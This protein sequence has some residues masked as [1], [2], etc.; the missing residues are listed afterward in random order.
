MTIAD[1]ILALV[2]LI[3]GV[4]GFRAGTTKALPSASTA[5]VGLVVGAR[6]SDQI[7]WGV[8][9]GRQVL[10]ALVLLGFG[11][12]GL[13]GGQLLRAAP[14]PQAARPQVPAFVR[15]RRRRRWEIVART[16]LT[17]LVGVAGGFLIA[18][19]IE[20]DR[21]L[22]DASDVTVSQTTAATTVPPTAVVHSTF[23][24]TAVPPTTAT[25]STV[26]T[27]TTVPATTSS[28]APTIAPLALSVTSPSD[29]AEVT[30]SRVTLTG[31]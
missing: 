7:R 29:G 5:L 17:L 25:P 15:W 14:A 6:V 23:P 27:A 21:T 26:G 24:T 8:G 22:T 3:A 9:A 11:A 18:R 2:V 28:A 31:T 20:S 19:A 12:I 16:G 13:A 30:S 4:V 10:A 1:A